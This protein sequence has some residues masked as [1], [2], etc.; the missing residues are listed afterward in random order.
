MIISGYKRTLGFK[1]LW[2]LMP[3][4]RSSTIVPRFLNFWNKEVKQKKFQ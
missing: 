2:T 4:D 3:A 1:D